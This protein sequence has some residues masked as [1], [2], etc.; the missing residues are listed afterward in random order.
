M[1]DRF[2]GEGA[3]FACMPTGVRVRMGGGCT[4]EGAAFAC[5]PMGALIYT[6]IVSRG[7]AIFRGKCGAPTGPSPPGC[8]IWGRFR[9]RRRHRDE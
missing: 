3:A 5:M 4:D 2:S 9:L 6:C 8:A 1:Y 7:C